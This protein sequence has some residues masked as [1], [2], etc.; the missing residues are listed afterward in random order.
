VQDLADRQVKDRMLLS[1]D[2]VR[3]VKLAGKVDFLP[4]DKADDA[5]KAKAAQLCHL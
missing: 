2:A 4:V 3:L 1:E 5:A